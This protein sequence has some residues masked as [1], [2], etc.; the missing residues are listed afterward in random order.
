MDSFTT[1]STYLNFF[2][3]PVGEEIV[4]NRQGW[5]KRRVA[6]QDELEGQVVA[7]PSPE[8]E[9]LDTSYYSLCHGFQLK[10]P[11]EQR[12]LRCYLDPSQHPTFLLAP[13]K[14]E[15][16]SKSP[17]ILQFHEILSDS[18][19]QSALEAFQSTRMQPQFTWAFPDEEGTREPPARTGAQA[20]LGIHKTKQLM[21]IAKKVQLITGLRVFGTDND[22]VSANK[23]QDQQKNGTTESQKKKADKM[24]QGTQAEYFRLT[25]YVAGRCA[26]LHAEADPDI[27]ASLQFYV[28]NSE[29]DVLMSS[30]FCWLSL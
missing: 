14:V 30:F 24:N 2:T 15:Q 26:M 21:R 23:R 19:I 25:E 22:H 11:R 6:V 27:M 13:L 16:L 17:R 10:S 18:E 5:T 12:K 3:A 29:N 8:L 4:T 20:S 7:T 9:R 28:S 1:P